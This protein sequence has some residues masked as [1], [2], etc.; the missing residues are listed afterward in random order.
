MSFRD[1]LQDLQ[2]DFDRLS[3]DQRRRLESFVG[4]RNEQVSEALNLMAQ[5]VAEMARELLPGF[6]V[7]TVTL[8]I[9]PWV[10]GKYG[11]LWCLVATEE[12]WEEELRGFAAAQA[13][14]RVERA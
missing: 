7:E 5:R 10:E 11:R 9:K 8:G 3:L 12:E 4:M 1:L 6:D 13:E 14:P 2:G